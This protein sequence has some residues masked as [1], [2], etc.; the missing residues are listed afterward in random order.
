M[1][2]NELKWYI[3]GSLIE[4]DSF[5]SMFN[6]VGGSLDL[7]IGANTNGGYNYFNGTMDEIKIYNYTL[8]DSQIWQ[9]YLAGNASRYPNIIV[10]GF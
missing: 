3:N 6:M 2:V 5:N 4:T 1:S 7:V 8:S 9:N 10:F